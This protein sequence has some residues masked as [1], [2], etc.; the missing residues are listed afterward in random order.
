MLKRRFGKIA[1]IITGSYFLLMIFLFL[2]SNA[3]TITSGTDE[4]SLYVVFILM[5]YFSP[6]VLFYVLTCAFIAAILTMRERRQELKSV[7]MDQEI[8][9]PSVEEI[10]DEKSSNAE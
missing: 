8:P 9:Q 1:L 5:F 10:E 2:A 7:Y 3:I 6:V 4:K